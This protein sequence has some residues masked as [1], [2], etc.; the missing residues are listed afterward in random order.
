MLAD[1]HTRGTIYVRS[2]VQT[3][4]DEK[5]RKK[6]IG[7]ILPQNSGQKILPT[8]LADKEI[9]VYASGLNSI[10]FFLF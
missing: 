4:Y 9:P 5:R 1:G 7:T 8:I 10:S 3:Q 6:T 2:Y